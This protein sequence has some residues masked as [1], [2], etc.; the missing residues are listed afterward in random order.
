MDQ[1]R[2][3][4]PE[5]TDSAQLGTNVTTEQ[6]RIGKPHAVEVSPISEH[7]ED[8]SKALEQQAGNSEQR[9]SQLDSS[10]TVPPLRTP[11][12]RRPATFATEDAVEQAVPSGPIENK[13]ITAVAGASAASSS[14]GEQSPPQEA[15]DS[16]SD[17]DAQ[18]LNRHGTMSSTAHT[19]SP[20]KESDLLRD[21][22][23]KSLSPAADHSQ[24]ELPFT[25][26]ERSQA[27]PRG[28]TRES[29][30]S[31][32]AYDSYWDDSEKTP[33]LPAAKMEA[34]IP[35]AEEPSTQAQ[36][37]PKSLVSTPVQAPALPASASEDMPP[38]SLQQDIEASDPAQ[39]PGL[40]RKFSWEMASEDS[41][42]PRDQGKHPSQS[43]APSASQ[44]SPPAASAPVPI[45]T[46]TASSA[47]TSAMSPVTEISDAE[48]RGFA[49]HDAAVTSAPD[50]VS[51]MSRESTTKQSEDPASVAEAPSSVSGSDNL[52]ST[53]LAEE[54]TSAGIAPNMA[55]PPPLESHPALAGSGPA[56]STPGNAPTQ[57]KPS[58][59]IPFRDIMGMQTPSQRIMKYNET[60]D[61][62]SSIDSGLSTWVENMRLQ[63]PEHANATPSFQNAL[64]Q[65]PGQPGAAPGQP[66][67]QPPAQQP[68]YQQYLNA[69]SPAP[70]GSSSSRSRLAGLPMPSQASSAFGN[71]GNQIGTK[72]KE[73]MQS[74]G[75]RSKD[76][77]S[78]GKSKLRGST[79]DKVFH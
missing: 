67:A 65:P 54:R 37:E 79:G 7:E 17:Y 16:P 72:S 41:T 70:G 62:F 59:I 32:S 14:P 8:T 39:S 21:E 20:V 36:I 30:Y 55:V 15:V 46:T 3:V 61:A 75:K 52:Q 9:S 38:P 13:H 60:R 11:S 29:T 42:M 48:T 5:Q 49:P 47:R 12:P 35:E 73:I 34:T 69:S 58:S 78:K 68:Y 25:D 22:I 18:S 33:S 51:Q 57:P 19:A 4:E 77:F 23:M 45:I 76:W 6:D 63:H 31:L 53:P 40:R 66:G 74:A 56:S 1:D 64:T 27:P 50:S 24:E 71:S 44:A 26:K 2:A 10:A 28:T 43:Q